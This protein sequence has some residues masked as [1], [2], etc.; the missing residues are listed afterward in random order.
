MYWRL[1]GRRARPVRYLV[2]SANRQALD[3]C[4]VASGGLSLVEGANRSRRVAF[5]V[6]DITN[7]EPGEG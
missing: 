2:I 6:T 5:A 4:E 7:R 1:D 3:A